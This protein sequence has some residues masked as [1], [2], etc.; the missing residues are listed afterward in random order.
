MTGL[1]FVNCG[2]KSLDCVPETEPWGAKSMSALTR[3]DAGSCRHGPAISTTKVVL[4]GWEK[5]AS[6]TW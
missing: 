5:V 6:H 4:A 1:Q 2:T 3:T